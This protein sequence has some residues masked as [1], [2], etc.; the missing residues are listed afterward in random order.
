MYYITLS[1]NKQN[2]QY[3]IGEFSTC[4][5]SILDGERFS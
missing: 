2:N 1:Q 4:L 3:Y 5:R